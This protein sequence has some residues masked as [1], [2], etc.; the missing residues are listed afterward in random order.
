MESVHDEVMEDVESS[1]SEE[2]E[3]VA[4]VLDGRQITFTAKHL[5]AILSCFICGGYFRNA[6]T[7]ATCFHTFCRSCLVQHFEKEGDT[8]EQHT[9]PR[10]GEILAPNPMKNIVRP[11]TDLQNIVDKIFPVG[12]TLQD[13]PTSQSSQLVPNTDKREVTFEFQYQPDESQQQSRSSFD[14]DDTDLFLDRPIIR[15]PTHTMV[16]TLKKYLL[17]KLPG[18]RSAD[19]IEIMCND[20]VLG[21]EWSLKFVLV[22]EWRDPTRALVL[23]YRRSTL[24]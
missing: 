16:K 15:V 17:L 23:G 11:D 1:S 8:F 24:S 7:I 21:S 22:A 5:N 6:H 20:K 10:C 3:G 4:P 18:F 19:E 2:E 12:A 14:D 13:S 9:C